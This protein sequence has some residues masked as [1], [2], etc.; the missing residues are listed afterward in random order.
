MRQPGT[1]VSYLRSKRRHK[2]AR[3][4][5]RPTLENNTFLLCVCRYMPGMP[6]CGTTAKLKDPTPFPRFLGY[7]CCALIPKQDVTLRTQARRVE[8]VV[9]VEQLAILPNG[10]AQRWRHATRCRNASLD[11]DP[12]RRISP[13][14][15]LQHH[16][17]PGTGM[18]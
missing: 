4:S 5:S 13:A 3:S 9:D 10:I 12:F 17:A 6:T 15:P 7:A 8:G 11:L 14:P 18:L 2:R 1:I 16:Q